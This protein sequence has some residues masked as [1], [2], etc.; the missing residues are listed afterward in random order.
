MTGFG[1]GPP[2]FAGMCAVLDELGIRDRERRMEIRGYW[3][4]MAVVEAEAQKK[5]RE[6]SEAERG[7]LRDGV[8]R[9][10]RKRPQRRR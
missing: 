7:E 8:D 10:G 1:A 6:K 9:G 4:S 5:A 2:T 3:R